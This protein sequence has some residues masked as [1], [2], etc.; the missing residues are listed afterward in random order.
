MSL[1]KTVILAD[2]SARVPFPGVPG[3]FVGLEPFEVSIID[4]F[5]AALVADKT[6]IEPPADP[7]PE[8]SSGKSKA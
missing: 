4:P 5:W 7:E 8:K 6:L 3:Q 2:A 1:R